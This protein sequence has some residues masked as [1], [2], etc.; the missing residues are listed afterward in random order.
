VRE[1]GG[2]RRLLPR[3]Q[4]NPGEDEAEL[5]NMG[6]GTFFVVQGRARGGYPATGGG[7]GWSLSRPCQW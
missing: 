5:G 7:A 1:F 2:A 4:G 6:R 3:W